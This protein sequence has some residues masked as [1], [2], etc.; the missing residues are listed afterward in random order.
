ML[1]TRILVG[2][3]LAVVGL[4]ILFLDEYL[5][6]WFPGW[7]LMVMGLGLATCYELFWVVG[8]SYKFASWLCFGG[9]V[10]LLSMNWLARVPAPWWPKLDL[11]TCLVF[12]FVAYFFALFLVEMAYYRQPDGVMVRMPLSLWMVAY[13]GILPSFLVQLRWHGYD[14]GNPEYDPRLGTM[15]LLLAIFVPKCCDIGAYF[16]GRW[17]GRN[18]L[19]PAISPKKTWEGALGGLALAALVTVLIDNVG[20]VPLLHQQWWAEI[21]FGVTV[22]SAG[23]LGDLAE[24]MIKRDCNTK[25]TSQAVPGFGGVLDVIDAVLFAAP[26]AYLWL[27]LLGPSI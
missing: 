16:T 23:I 21:G 15:A 26:V 24:S 8:Q 3:I 6:P 11:S 2:S 22:G 1:R 12:A 25:D 7:Y 19:S 4:G 20:P 9:V 13:L 10:V 27:V 17:F 18:R 5:A 14:P